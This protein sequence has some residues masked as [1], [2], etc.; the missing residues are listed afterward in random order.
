M[1]GDNALQK[2]RKKM[3]NFIYRSTKLSPTGKLWVKFTTNPQIAEK[4]GGVITCRSNS[5]V[6][7]NPHFFTDKTAQPSNPN[8]FSYPP[9]HTFLL[10]SKR[11]ASH[12]TSRLSSSYPF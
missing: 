6:H 11:G 5:S 7:P 8:F 4:L 12:H 2:V 10:E 3:R 9:H 1:Q